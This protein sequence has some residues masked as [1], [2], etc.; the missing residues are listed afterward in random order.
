MYYGESE[1][2]P[3]KQTVAC[4]N[5]VAHAQKV[6]RTYVCIMII[7]SFMEHNK[8]L[9]CPLCFVVHD[10]ILVIL[11]RCNCVDQTPPTIWTLQRLPWNPGGC[12][13][14]ELWG[15]KYTPMPTYATFHNIIIIIKYIRSAIYDFYM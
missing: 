12:G 1:D 4:N 5:A 7:V 9:L 6:L 11:F 2:M 8:L 10:N 14:G 13:M 15:Y 3:V